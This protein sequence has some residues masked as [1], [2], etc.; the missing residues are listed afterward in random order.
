MNP[1][2]ITISIPEKVNTVIETL[3]QNGHEAYIVGGCVRD[4]ILGRTPDDWDITTSAMPEDVKRLFRRTVDTGIKHGTV[5]VLIGNEQFEV[6]TY[7]IDGDYGD[8]RHPDNV[9]FTSS[10]KE[11]LRRRDFTINAMAYSEE[12]GLIDYYDGLGDIDRKVI[13]AV[14][15]AEERFTEDALRIMRAV[16][17]SAQLGYSIEDKTKE[18]AGELAGTLTKI[19]AERINIEL[20]KL[21]VSP[22]PEELRTMYELGITAVI[23]P[24]F[25]VCMKTPQ[26]NLHH[27]FGVGEHIIHSVQAV[28]ADKVLR[29]TM[30]F[31]DIGKP[32]CHYRGA[33]GIDHCHGHAPVSAE[34]AARIMKRLKFDNDTEAKVETLVR[35]H[36]INMDETPYA[37]RKS[38]A[39][40]GEDLFPLLFEI[41]IADGAAQSEFRL[42]EKK[43]KVAAWE[44]I[45]S[46]IIEDGDCLGLKD[47]KVNGQDLIDRGMKP[48]REI[49]I[50]LRRMLE[51]VL[52]Y[53]SHNTEDYLLSHYQPQKDEPDNKS[54]QNS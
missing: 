42:E 2:D 31:H 19:S 48:G 26:N 37:V 13:R 5:T 8:G 54:G 53:P 38:I 16:R 52:Q 51:D 24:E 44:S 36:D 46:R 17:F 6:T 34:I 15:D 50:T 3:R 22:H 41:K 11:D 45:Y 23:M 18:A 32:D 12:D 20:T 43:M 47:L 29:Y 9:V 25:D 14:G 28:R 40:I 39:V 7:R 1:A 21:L 30:L 35:Y 33:D 27:M 4:S 10:L 49:G